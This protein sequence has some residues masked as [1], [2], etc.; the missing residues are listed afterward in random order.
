MSFHGG[1][2]HYTWQQAVN[3]TYLNHHQQSENIDL[4][5]YLT[6]GYKLEANNQELI[7]TISELLCENENYRQDLEAADQAYEL[8]QYMSYVAQSTFETQKHYFQSAEEA[9]AQAQ[10]QMMRYTELLADAC[11]KTRA[12]EAQLRFRGYMVDDLNAVLEDRQAMIDEYRRRIGQVE[13][14]CWAADVCA[15]RYLLV[16]EGEILGEILFRISR[17]ADEMEDLC[18]SYRQFLADRMDIVSEVGDG[19]ESMWRA[20]SRAAAGNRGLADL[21]RDLDDLIHRERSGCGLNPFLERNFS[22]IIAEAQASCGANG[23]DA[24]AQEESECEYEPPETT[25]PP[26]IPI[27]PGGHPNL[28]EGQMFASYIQPPQATFI[29]QN[30]WFHIYGS[31]PQDTVMFNDTQDPVGQPIDSHVF[32]LDVELTQVSQRIFDCVMRPANARS[33]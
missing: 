13:N 1:F 29:G 18:R 24:Q 8:A 3:D 4:Q 2:S 7:Q 9:Y 17:A 22:H 19:G 15:W 28:G 20:A 27:T 16:E 11:A 25:P 5:Q 12:W 21:E 6:D 31:A 32:T 14:P 10:E 33:V 30:N 26:S 23:A